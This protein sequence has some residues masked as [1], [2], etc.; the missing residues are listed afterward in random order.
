MLAP[1]SCR[2]VAA[3]PVRPRLPRLL[4]P[5]QLLLPLSRQRPLPLVLDRLRQPLLQFLLLHLAHAYRKVF[6]SLN[7]ILT[8]LFAMV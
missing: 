3:R 2:R 8:A 5:L 6:D 1:V 7:S 4:H